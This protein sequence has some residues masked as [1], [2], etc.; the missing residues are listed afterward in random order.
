M[1][2]A[3]RFYWLKLNEDF[4][5]QKEIKQ[6]RKIA[7][8]PIFT[9][10]YLKMLLRS[11]GDNG[12]LY[13]EGIEDDFASELALDIDESVE[14]V[15][16]TISYLMS[17]HILIQCNKT[18]WEILTAKEMTGSEG[19]SA[20]RMRKMRN[21]EMLLASHCD[22]RVTTSDT[23]IE[24]ELEKEIEL[25]NRE[26]KMRKTF[27]KPTIQQIKDYALSIN[28]NLDADAFYDYYESVGWKIGNKPMKD[29]KCTI[30]NWRRRDEQKG[31]K[32]DAKRP[33]H[34]EIILDDDQIA[35]ID[36]ITSRGEN[37]G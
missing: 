23:E 7:G 24:I 22:R 18:E 9:I 36:E 35:A 37:W 5:R 16:I 28:Y 8:G 6:L 33:R 26:K 14:D 11:M 4:F 30:R 25:E 29:W 20:R 15:R 19:E 17:K 21:R 34:P 3:K 10:I 13:Y 2:E 1:S 32:T 27:V 12:R 31:L